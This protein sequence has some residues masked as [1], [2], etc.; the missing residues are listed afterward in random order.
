MS[1]VIT[2][3]F[4][5]QGY[6]IIAV[7]NGFVMGKSSTA[8]SPYVV[9]Q[10]DNDGEGVSCGHYFVDR[11]EAEWDFCARAFEWFEDNMYIHMIENDEE[12]PCD[13]CRYNTNDCVCHRHPV[14]GGCDGKSHCENKKPLA[15]D[16]LGGLKEIRTHISAAAKLVDEMCT[17]VDRLKERRRNDNTVN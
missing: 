10:V 5:I 9:W 3:G 13:G 11:E 17:E 7:A 14:C 1:T 12:S 4:T 6:T 16:L 8:P 2:T 15:D